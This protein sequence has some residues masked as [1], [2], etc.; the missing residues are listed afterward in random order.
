MYGMD[1]C[2]LRHG[3]KALFPL[4]RY[5]PAQAKGGQYSSESYFD[6]Y[7]S[8]LRTLGTLHTLPPRYIYGR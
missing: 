8:Y 1:A 3:D 6:F 7:C 4:K 5:S 2:G